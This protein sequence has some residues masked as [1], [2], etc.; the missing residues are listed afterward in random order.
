MGKL[1]RKRNRT[2][3]GEKGEKNL[4]HGIAEVP[5]RGKVGGIMMACQ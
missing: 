1:C 4:E 2:G 3:G 5:L